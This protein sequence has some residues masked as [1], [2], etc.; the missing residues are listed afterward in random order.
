[1]QQLFGQTPYL[2]ERND[3]C[4]PCVGCAKNCYDFNPRAAYLADLNEDDPH[5]SN[6]RK[7]FVG[8]LPALVLAYFTAP[9]PNSLG[10]AEHYGRMALAIG[11]GIGSFFVLEVILRVSAA[12][13][14]PVYGA[15]AITL[16][17][18]YGSKVVAK[19]VTGDPAAWIVWPLRLLVAILAVTWIIRTWRKEEH[20]EAASATDPGDVS[21][22]LGAAAQSAAA[23]AHDIEIT[24]GESG[25]RITT[26]VGATLLE[27][28]EGQDQ[29][30]E[31]GCRMGVCGADPVAI[32][33]GANN[34][35][36]PTSDE[37]ST[38]QRLGLDVQ[39]NRM[40]C[41]AR[42]SG[43]VTFSLKPDRSGPAVAQPV[44]FGFDPEVRRVVVLGNGIAGVTAAD[45]L[46]RR[47]P[48]CEI[49]VVA[50]EPYPLY[51]R[52]GISRL[53]YGR[54]AMVGLH[55]L[56][57]NWY[58]DN[59]ITCWLNTRSTKIDR[60]ARE[61]HLGT[62]ERLPYDRLILATG[63][64]AHVPSLPGWGLPGTFVLRSADDALWIRS[65]VQR[66]GARRAIVAGG[67]LLGL[68]AAYALHKLGLSVTVLERGPWLMRR[69]LD[70]RAGELLCAY[71]TNLGLD[72]R[73]NT[74]PH[75]VRG[76]GR[77][78]RVV[79][80]DGSEVAADLILAAAGVVPS[81]E[82]AAA[83][84][85]EVGYGVIVDEQLRTNDPRIFAVGDLVE[86][87]GRVLGL[88]PVAVEQAEV[89]AE[90]AAGGTRAYTGTVPVTMLKVVGVDLTS[91]GR[92][93]PDDEAGERARVTEDPE[94]L[95]YRKLV[96]DV[97]GRCVGAILLGFPEDAAA[98]TEAVKTRAVAVLRDP[99]GA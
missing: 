11:V 73:L 59:R 39:R 99:S 94:S 20:F 78:E 89:A 97:D 1:M 50:S 68:E 43:P 47:H 18:W 7:L 42:V 90:N 6:A 38:L 54:S 93:E 23:A 29:R 26:R 37:R 98:I 17:Y 30:I 60:E 8:A 62:G 63:S 96:S 16:F 2:L 57:D 53:I 10:V 44:E 27:I 77:L 21:V 86:W 52:M 75:E 88:W 34:I 41:C 87:E 22:K 74:A 71:L 58:D 72:V 95:R 15:A 49:S 31:A 61:V 79:L 51:N 9:D 3:H 24:F 70:E 5:Y 4:R 84:G 28:A 81:T 48:D 91:V 33:S 19:T 35:S 32:L 36:P 64:E 92:I 85:L 25:A 67:G 55:L 65:Y 66:A 83:A 12:R 13:L 56:P 45:Q 82:L 80:L 14:A 40:A 69:Q 76:D 46:R